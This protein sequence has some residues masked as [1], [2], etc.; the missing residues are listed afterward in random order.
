MSHYN[1]QVDMGGMISLLSEH[2]Y[3][4]PNVFLRELIQN[5]V[6][7]ITARR[8]LEPEHHGRVRLVLGRDQ[9]RQTLD[10]V[11]DGIGLNAE[12]IHGFLST[13]G[14][15]SKTSAE[16]LGQFGIGLLAGFLISDT[17]EII[18]RSARGGPAL[19]WR[20]H[21]DGQYTLEE[22]DEDIPIGTTARLVA[23][24]AEAHRLE[25]AHLLRQARDLAGLL[26]IPITV[27]DPLFGVETVQQG[28]PPWARD[29]LSQAHAERLL[30]QFVR[31]FLDEDPMFV[32]PLEG[33]GFRG[34]ACVSPRSIGYA[35]R[36]RHRVT[37]KGMLVSDNIDDLL[38]GWAPFVRCVLDV[39]ALTPLASREGFQRDSR[40]RCL[41]RELDEALRNRFMTLPTQSPTTFDAF[42]RVHYRALEELI[43]SDTACLEVFGPHWPLISS[44]GP[45]RLADAA[46]DPN[47]L[48]YVVDDDVFRTLTPLA[49][50]QG[51]RLIS[52]AYGRDRQ[53][54]ERVA[55]RRPELVLRALNVE[56]LLVSLKGELTPAE[57]AFEARAA[58][59][60]AEAELDIELRPIRPVSLPVLLDISPSARRK[61]G[62][63]RDRERSAARWAGIFEDLDEA[64]LARNPRQGR[65][66]F[67]IANDLIRGVIHEPDSARQA[68][69]IETL[70]LEA[71]LLSR[72]PMRT[73]DMDRLSQ[74]LHRLLRLAASP[75]RPV[76]V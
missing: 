7:A 22:L 35:G 67:N 64:Q 28:A 8:R 71:R 58:R 44:E 9:H 30:R 59:Q 41:H 51:K 49:E 73:E 56:D 46:R 23:R 16:E 2:L 3:A 27:E 50:A 47:M 52:T 60:L 43:L 37:L 26:P 31:P 38:P 69:M 17:I 63:A 45:I 25:P 40:L 18:S 1:F 13:L 39:D 12:E 74:S 15:S 4:S 5:A 20:A 48:G 24:E 68:L 21:A 65:L 29:V 42:V 34:V 72:L 55:Q 32:L 33:D 11:D 10:V 61:M 57:Q 6:D 70:W 76:E 14:R 53:I 75:L 19:R 66:V 62:R 54:I 36:M